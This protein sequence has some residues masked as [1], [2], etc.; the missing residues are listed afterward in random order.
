MADEETVKTE[1]RSGD[2]ADERKGSGG[3]GLRR[4]ILRLAAVLVVA[5]VAVVAILG[6][7]NYEQEEPPVRG[8]APA[9][10]DAYAE[11]VD[12][13]FCQALA[14]QL[15]ELG[16]DPAT[17]NRS[18]GSPAEREAAKLIE[19]TMKDIGLKNVTMDEVS[20]DGWTY[21]GA[22][23]D[24]IDASG[25]SR[26]VT[27]G[28][29][30]VN[31]HASGE[32]IPV[33]YLGRGTAAD[34]ENI[35]VTGKLA[36]IEIDQENDWWINYPAYQAKLMG[37]RA[38]LAVSLM[39]ETIGDR[40]GSQD[41]CGPADAPA[42]AISVDDSNAIRKA[43]E[44]KGYE[45]GGAQQ[46]DV[47]F[48]A[49]SRVTED[50][51]SSNVWGEIPGKSDE[52]ILFIAH[53]DGYYHS[54]YDDAS[55]VGLTLG[56]AK[57]FVES[58]YEPQKTLRFV[59]HGAEEWGRTD[60]EADWATGAYE[61]IVRLRPEWAQSAF[62]LV[63]IDGGYPLEAMERFKVSVP[64]ELESFIRGSILSFGD[65]SSISITAD[66]GLPSPYREDFIYSASGV[67]TIANEGGEGDEQYFAG[68]YH[69]NKDLLEEGGY[70]ETGAGAIE[71]Y[72]GYAAMM[73]DELPLRPL[74]FATGFEALKESYSNGNPAI[75]AVN[76]HLLANVDRAITAAQALDGMIVR[77]NEEYRA[78][79]ITADAETAEEMAANALDLNRKIFKAYKLI[80]D[81]L[82]RLD[83]LMTA[84]FANEGVQN[85]IGNLDAALAALEEG[86]AEAA[87]YEHLSSIEFVGGAAFFDKGTCDYFIAGMYTGLVGTWAEGRVVGQAC[88]ADDVVRSLIA[89]MADG[90]IDYRDEIAALTE[91]REGQEI[92]LRDI[93][94][95]QSIGLVRLMDAMNEPVDL[96]AQKE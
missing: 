21:R 55:G 17:G 29:Y 61:Q 43:I 70:S 24:F 66:G 76:S 38:V 59:A 31:I 44:S 90:D 30:A 56:M 18:A 16:D 2:G 32:T 50:T 10:Y 81:E 40:V 93:Y 27:L 77:Y 33:V 14:T 58:G 5:A 20:S 15:S 3:S 60:T 12:V 62:A 83:W 39:E 26:H 89:K 95:E 41:I 8:E 45:S 37:A 23:L 49:D 75:D 36:L 74:N 67:P 80:Q 65:R 46:I 63:N 9:G 11:A 68:M 25:K 42:L 78:A 71:Q 73:L 1:Q 91:L 7:G 88:Y 94:A 52:T 72:Y 48:T 79:R 54:F 69:S 82:L 6:S 28:G 92:A 86:D 13:T 85:N 96:N 4:I 19:Q 84:E 51:G 47:Q 64:R 53:Y 22:S 35:D 34:Y 57:A 87:V